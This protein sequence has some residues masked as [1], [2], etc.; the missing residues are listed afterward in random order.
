MKRGDGL[1]FD[2]GAPDGDE[3]GGAVYDIHPSK[4]RSAR[5]GSSADL[6]SGPGQLNLRRIKVPRHP[7]PLTKSVTYNGAVWDHAQQRFV[8]PKKKQLHTP[9][10]G[11]T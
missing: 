1:V 6:K 9:L 4:Q 10:S 2:S 3:E 7:H 5:S 11:R 8:L